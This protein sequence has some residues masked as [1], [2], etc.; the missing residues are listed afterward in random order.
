MLALAVALLL[1]VRTAVA[2]PAPSPEQIWNRILPS[3]LTYIQIGHSG[4]VIYDFQDPDCPPC[5]ALYKSEM[6]LV[7]AHRLTVRYVPVAFLTKNSVPEAAAWLQA[8]NPQQ[9]LERFET[10]IGAALRKQNFQSV[11]QVVP[12]ARILQALR[13]NLRVMEQLGFQGT[14]AVLYRLQNGKIGA[15]PGYVSEEDLAARLPR[16]RS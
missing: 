1:G 9:A 10:G 5:H 13:R 6:P 3:Q 7:R 14:P 8:R 16:M 4:P 15:F 11:A 2:S 12:T